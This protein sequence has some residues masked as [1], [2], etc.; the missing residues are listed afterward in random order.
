MHFLFPGLIIRLYVLQ[1]QLLPFTDLSLPAD[2]AIEQ[3]CLY[4]QYRSTGAIGVYT[5]PS[6]CDHDD[7]GS[8]ATSMFESV[9]EWQYRKAMFDGLQFFISLTDFLQT[10]TIL[11]V[12]LCCV[13]YAMVI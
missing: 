13:T 7:Q 4:K 2:K 6:A 1:Q 8:E 5:T 12:F 11:L 9:F 10:K 3:G